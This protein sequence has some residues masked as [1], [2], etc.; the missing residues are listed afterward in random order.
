MQIKWNKN[1]DCVVI[2]SFSLVIW[3]I[4][5]RNIQTSMKGNP[6][7]IFQKVVKSSLNKIKITNNSKLI[8]FELYYN[9]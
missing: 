5:N 7:H 4:E 6:R 9:F 1:I 8:D 2:Q 3:P